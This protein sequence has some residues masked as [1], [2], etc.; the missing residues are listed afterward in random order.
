MKKGLL[1]VLAVL[2]V[3][4]LFVSCNSDVSANAGASS[5]DYAYVT[6]DKA[7][8][9]KSVS[10]TVDPADAPSIDDLYW[11]YQAIKASGTVHE[12]QTSGWT[13]VKSSGKGLSGTIGPFSVGEWY[14]ALAG[15]TSESEPSSC[16][17]VTY[18][19]NG[20]TVTWGGYADT[21]VR[22]IG[23]SG[24]SGYTTKENVTLA[25]NQSDPTYIP[26]SLQQVNMTDK[27]TVI[28]DG[29]QLV[30]SSGITAGENVWLDV[31]KGTGELGD[32]IV[33]TADANGAVVP[34][35]TSRE[36]TIGSAVEQVT[37]NFKLYDKTGENAPV[38]KEAS[39]SFLATKGATV[40]LAGSLDAIE[41]YGTFTAPDDAVAFIASNTGVVTFKSKLEDAIENAVTGDTVVLLKDVDYSNNDSLIK[42]VLNGITLDLQEHTITTSLHNESFGGEHFTIKNGTFKRGTDTGSYALFIGWDSNTATNGIL[43]NITVHNGL[44]VGNASSVELRNSTVLKDRSADAYGIWCQGPSTVKVYDSTVIV[45]TS[46]SKD[47]YVFGVGKGE[48]QGLDCG[49]VGTIEVYS[50]AFNKGLKSFAYM[51]SGAVAGTNLKICGGTF[52][53]DPSAYVADGYTAIE[54]P[55][56]T[57]I[58]SEN[59]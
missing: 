43:E 1:L 22:Y 3:A 53:A 24:T 38:V 21:T 37:L 32:P 50:G 49:V 34:T 8:A 28:L 23:I 31:L 57:W 44:N 45:S 33:V 25:G 11:Y 30:G 47:A 12:G 7:S 2:L 5:K 58:V 19:L 56:G 46:S 42:F 16:P 10:P 51:G 40:T 39:V 35:D 59:N 36:F 13:R 14:F 55:V 4:G 29:L 27:V 15:I 9:S 52:D 17:N 54:D 20:D 26:M 41:V 48:T 18:S 6:F